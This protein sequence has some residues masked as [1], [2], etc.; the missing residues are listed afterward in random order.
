MQVAPL[1]G[2]L[3]LELTSHTITADSHATLSALRRLTHLGLKRCTGIPSALSQLTALQSLVIDYPQR[4][5]AAAASAAL[6][7]AL[8]QLGQLTMLLGRGL[9]NQSVCP[10]PVTLGQLS[11]LQQLAWQHDGIE[12]TQSAAAAAAAALPPGLLSGAAV[13][14]GVSLATLAAAKQLTYLGLYPPAEEDDS[15][16]VESIIEWAAACPNLRRVDIDYGGENDVPKEVARSALMVQRSR[17][18]LIIDFDSVIDFDDDD[19]V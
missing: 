17:P 12:E 2:L 9:P 3:R 8:P 11:M 19:D 18:S 4:N 6:T 13:T 10:L 1:T 15:E 5:N 16:E 7:A 14:L